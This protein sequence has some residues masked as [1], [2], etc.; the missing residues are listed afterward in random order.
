MSLASRV[1][2]A[3][4]A[5]IFLAT[6]LRF[7]FSLDYLAADGS[8]LVVTSVFEQVP[9]TPGSN[10]SAPHG[11]GDS[12][13]DAV[14]CTGSFVSKEQSLASSK[15]TRTR[16]LAVCT[17][18]FSNDSGALVA[19]ETIS[20]YFSNTRDWKMA[21]EA[22]D[23]TSVLQKPRKTRWL[24]FLLA[25]SVIVFLCF[26]LLRGRNWSKDFAS[27]GA[28]VKRTPSSIIIVVLIPIVA[29]ALLAMLISRSEVPP[30]A[31]LASH[32]RIFDPSFMFLAIL[33]APLTEEL[34]YRGWMLPLH[35]QF[36][37]VPMAVITTS[38][39]F[40]AMHAPDIGSVAWAF[41]IGMVLGY[42]RVAFNSVL[43]CVALHS[44]FNTLL[45]G[46]EMFLVATL[47]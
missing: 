23:S 43:A 5:S 37:S 40:A 34:L 25:N 44:L 12:T 18:H 1:V 8:S 47:Q 16:V 42:I 38:A 32:A 39:I 30:V 15:G 3:F 41:S 21:N 14:E 35:Q 46:S 33:I 28:F 7:V 6:T 11:L 13:S 17:F 19:S 4:A 2:L 20:Q 29:V 36:I 22:V 10:F 31:L 45:L 27:I 24:F 26:A 9:F